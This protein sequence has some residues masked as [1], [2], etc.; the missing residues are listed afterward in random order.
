MLSGRL[1]LERARI[2]HADRHGLI[3][4]DRGALSVQ[5]GCLLFT[6]GGGVLD[7]GAY[8]LP[9]QTVSTIMLGPGTTVSHDALRIAARHGTAL[10][11]VGE[12]GS[13]LYTAPAIG[14]DRS[15]LARAQATLWANE[16]SRLEVARRMYAMRMGRI[17]P[18]RDIAVLRGIEGARVKESY[19]LVAESFG[20]VWKRRKYDR[21][22]PEAADVANQALN[23]AAAAVQ[24][25]ASVAVTALSALPQLG[26]IHEDSSQSFVFDI[27]DLFREEVTLRI[28]F[29]VAKRIEGGDDRSVDRLVRQTASAE[30]R[31][32]AVIPSMMDKVKALLSAGD[33]EGE[34]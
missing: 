34:P 25:A 11:A 31:R 15:A 13:R 17:L 29:S 12:D 28:A 18:H 20:L 19:K 14:P 5:D 2:P 26:F 1:G 21:T 24:S 27:A 32:K 22:R 4:V 7:A 23:H 3:Y 33:G 8:Q 6:S 9:H 16:E 30:F 10:C